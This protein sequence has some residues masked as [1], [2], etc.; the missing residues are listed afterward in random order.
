[1]GNKKI[2]LLIRGLITALVWIIIVAFIEIAFAITNLAGGAM[3]DIG[4]WLPILF[5]LLITFVIWNKQVWNVIK[6]EII[7]HTQHQIDV[8]LS[9]Q[10]SNL[11]EDELQQARSKLK[12]AK[13]ELGLNSAAEKPKKSKRDAISEHIRALSD[14]DLTRI[15][16]RLADDE[17]DDDEVIEVLNALES[18]KKEE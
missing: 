15:K 14:S 2:E 10:L 4:Y 6:Q 13:A 11:S 18:Q 1:M 3:P 7:D 16:N 9:G 8:Q 17:L 5:G 12:K